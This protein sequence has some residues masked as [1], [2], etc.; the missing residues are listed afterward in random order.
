MAK[1]IEKT[2]ITHSTLRSTPLEILERYHLEIGTAAGWNEETQGSYINR[3]RV[4]QAFIDKVAP[5]VPF[6]D[7]E[8]QD[9]QN[10]LDMFLK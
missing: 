4:I 5:N 7:L 1:Q 9:Y 6:E 8:F 3:L 2:K 10:A